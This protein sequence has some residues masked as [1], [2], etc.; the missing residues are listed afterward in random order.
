ME[1]DEPNGKGPVDRQRRRSRRDA[2]VTYRV[3][4]DITDSRPPI[5]RRLELAS[6]M[7]LDELHTVIQSSF[8][9]TDSHLHVFAI[10]SSVH[11]LEADRYLCPFDVEDGEAGVPEEEVRLD[12]VL[13]EVGDTLLYEYDYGDGWEHR[14]RLEAVTD[15]AGGEARAVCVDGERAGPP[16][17]CGGI[18]GYQAMLA[19]A[20]D[21]DPARFN[22][23]DV[24]RALSQ[25]TGRSTQTWSP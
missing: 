22:L 20:T 5:W 17:D 3:R 6:D 19:A 7:F 12:E 1:P 14:L 23:A 11:D 4:M 10:G 24:N 9:W 25:Q 16:E 15:R 18:G 2:V 8:S 21:F 13:V